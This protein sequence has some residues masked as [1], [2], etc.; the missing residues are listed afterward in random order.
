MGMTRAPDEKQKAMHL[1]EPSGNA[2]DDTEPP[3]GKNPHGSEVERIHN[4][5]TTKMMKMMTMMMMAKFI[6]LA[7]VL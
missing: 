3:S 6:L 4:S 7:Y 5:A 2:T 1:M